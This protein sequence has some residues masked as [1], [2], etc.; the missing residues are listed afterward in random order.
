MLDSLRVL[1][2]S[3][4]ACERSPFPQTAFPPLETPPSISSLP[5][6]SHSLSLAVFSLLVYFL[7]ASYSLSP[8]ASR[9]SSCR[10]FT[11][12][13]LQEEAEKI[14][15]AECRPPATIHHPVTRKT[16][17]SLKFPTLEA[18]GYSFSQGQWRSFQGSLVL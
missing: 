12:A 5:H 2:L 16:S 15:Q 10:L 1:P 8:L 14:P 17:F 3:W 13:V 4:A 9:L 18:R 7:P 6:C 11:R